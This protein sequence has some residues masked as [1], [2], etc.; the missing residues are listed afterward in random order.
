MLA[1]STYTPGTDFLFH[2]IF[3]GLGANL[4]YVFITMI[5]ADFTKQLFCEKLKFLSYNVSFFADYIGVWHHFG[6]KY[7]VESRFFL[8]LSRFFL[9]QL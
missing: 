3:S 6:V 1:R 4:G 5:Q 9:L 8:R 2:V 7:W